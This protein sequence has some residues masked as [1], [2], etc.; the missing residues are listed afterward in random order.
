MSS[1][2]VC[3]RIL[4]FHQERTALLDVLFETYCAFLWTFGSYKP[5]PGFDYIQDLVLTCTLKT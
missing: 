2:N 3:R 4:V 1:G 5:S